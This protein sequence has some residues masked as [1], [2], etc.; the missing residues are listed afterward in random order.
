MALSFET[1]NPNVATI[2]Q[3]RYKT[4]RRRCQKNIDIFRTIPQDDATPLRILK[5][6]VDVGPVWASEVI[7]AKSSGLPFEVIEPGEDLDQRD[8]IN[9]YIC[10]LKDAQ[11]P[12]N[13]KKFMEFIRSPGP[14]K[15]YKKYGFLPR[16]DR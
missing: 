1:L 7:H 8:G 13:A 3:Y 15:I 11:N 10:K 2:G 4:S 16:S 9:Y 12:G 14:Q 6:T 5:K